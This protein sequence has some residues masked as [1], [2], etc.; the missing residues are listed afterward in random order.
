MNRNTLIGAIIII[1]VLGG[2][3]WYGATRP[4]APAASTVATSTI[5]EAGPYVE[6]GQYFDITANY[7]TTTPLSAEADQAA[8][9]Q[10]RTWISG[11]IAQFKTNGN[12][13]NLTQNDIHMMGYD[14]GRKET[15]QIKYLIASSPRTVSYIYTEY[16]D[17]LGAHGNTFFKTFTFDT[18]TG[19]LLSL[20]DVFQGDYL[21]TLSQLA[22]AKLPAIIGQGYDLT[23]IKDGTTPDAKNFQSFFFDNTDFVV[24]FPP[25][26][27]APYSSGPQTLRIPVAQLD[28]VLQPAYRP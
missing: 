27:V 22:R 21:A 26:Q 15:L 12:F 10:M 24:L 9:G 13:D 11:E 1:V 4:A 5:P 7:P 3:V 25:Y 28:S 14:Q 17:T 6:H 8:R 2:I 23:F 20:S 18:E 16:L 19:A